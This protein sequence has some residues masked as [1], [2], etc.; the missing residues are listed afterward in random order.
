GTAADIWHAP[1]RYPVRCAPIRVYLGIEHSNSACSS[2]YSRRSMFKL[3]V[4][5][6]SRPNNGE[7]DTRSGTNTG[8]ADPQHIEIRVASR[9]I[10]A[11]VTPATVA[12]SSP[13]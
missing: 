8:L 13:V 12:M 3:N 1:K 6:S 5:I 9:N 2:S 7:L 4:A 11:L 10:Q